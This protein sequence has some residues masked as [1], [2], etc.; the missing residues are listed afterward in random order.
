MVSVPARKGHV[1]LREVLRE[2]GRRQILNLLI[3]AGAELN[4]AAIAEGIVDKMV[5]FYAPKI[6]GTGG[7][8]LA[9]IAVERFREGARA[10]AVDAAWIW[11]RFRR[12]RI[13][14]RC[15]PG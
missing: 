6:M 13:F 15:L 5:L 1:E 8:P 7:V 2:L 9:Q 12:G 14:S 4:G 10:F 11:T 3:E